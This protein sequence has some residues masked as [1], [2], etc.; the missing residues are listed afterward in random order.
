MR[1]SMMMLAVSLALLLAAGSAEAGVKNVIVMISDGWGQTGL[2]ATAYWNGE[3]AGYEVDPG[4]NVCGMTN[5]MYHEGGET[6]PYGGGGFVGIYGYDPDLAWA[7]WYYMQN[8]ATDSA[9]AG[10]AMSAGEKTYKGSIGMGVG[11]GPGGRVPLVH[12]MQRAEELGKATG[13]VTSVPLSHATPACFIAHNESRNNYAEIAQEMIGSDMEVIMG[14][15]HPNYGG[16]G[17]WDPGDPSVPGDWKYVGGYELWNELTGGQTDW[18]FID[19]KAAFEALADGT[20]QA[21]KVFGVAQVSHTLQHNRAGDSVP[22]GGNYNTT[23]PPYTDPMISNV[24]SL[25]TM[26]RGAL[27]VLGQNPNGFA[28]MIEGGAIDWAGHARLMGRWIEEQDDFNA[29]FDAVVEWVETNSNW[30]ETLVVVTG[31]HETGYL[32]GAGVDPEDPATWFAPVA[33]NG[34]GVVPS[35]YFY[36]APGD[37][38]QNPVSSAGHT[39]EAIPFFYKGY[40]STLLDEYADEYDPVVGPYLDNIELA[41]AIFTLLDEPTPILEYEPLEPAVDLNVRSASSLLHEN[42]PNPFRQS[43]NIKFDIP[44]AAHAMVQ[45]LDVQGRQIQTLAN[46]T[47]APGTYTMM[48]DGTGANGLRCASGTYYYRLTVNGRIDTKRMTLLQ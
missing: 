39:N 25:A 35:F 15:G 32:W 7:D 13:V 19:E 38:W 28:M 34:A 21:D 47:L 18:T 23:L 2:D 37:D 48:W 14:C 11:T 46:E 8:Y 16:D 29:A 17:E 30:N 43:T 20:L 24:P 26:T 31:D 9:A 4:W 1:R 27:N 36:S 12:F 42:W 33:D 6:P 3:R 5:Y 40:G 45:V 22:Y 44:T 41:M 10:T